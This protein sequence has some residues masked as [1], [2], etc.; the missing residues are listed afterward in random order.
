MFA[1]FTNIAGTSASVT[2]GH[3]V[4]KATFVEDVEG[5]GEKKSVMAVCF[6]V[7]TSEAVFSGTA[8]TDFSCRSV[9]AVPAISMPCDW[10]KTQKVVFPDCCSEALNISQF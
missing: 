2:E 5:R 8:S 7:E 10:L 9:D 3:G 1:C 4:M 6:T